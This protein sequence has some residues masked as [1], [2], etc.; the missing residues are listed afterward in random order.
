M[1]WYGARANACCL[2]VH[3]DSY[4]FL[5]LSHSISLSCD[6]VIM[7]VCPLSAGACPVGLSCFLSTAVVAA[8]GGG[9]GSQFALHGSSVTGVCI[10]RSAAVTASDDWVVHDAFSEA[11]GVAAQPPPQTCSVTR[12]GPGARPLLC[13]AGLSCVAQT[14]TSSSSSGGV[15][16]GSCVL[17]GAGEGTAAGTTVLSDYTDTAGVVCKPAVC[18]R[19][20]GGACGVTGGGACGADLLCT[21]VTAGNWEGLARCLDARAAP[22]TTARKLMVAA[23]IGV[24]SNHSDDSVCGGGNSTTAPDYSLALRGMLS[25]A[26]RV[27]AGGG[28][29][30]TA[31]DGTFIVDATVSPAVISAALTATLALP[32]LTA[33]L[34]VAQSSECSAD[35]AAVAG[36]VEMDLPGVVTTA[37]RLRGAGV[38]HCT[39]AAPFRHRLV[40][41]VEGGD[42][43]FAGGL[44]RLQGVA[45][46]VD[47]FEPTLKPPVTRN[48]KL[49]FGEPRSYFDFDFKLRHYTEDWR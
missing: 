5:S 48:S 35:G 27:T 10:T 42:V 43:T 20:V 17:L 30:S 16:Y 26:A 18:V 3:A 46:Q 33:S 1:T 8:A 29:A 21:P 28:G 39:S 2:L 4:V 14:A 47:H 45:M 13:A 12:C 15:G 32:G 9:T 37:A 40:A 6:V 24:Y 41:A 22:G 34:S 7:S 36:W 49:R 25:G 19:S 11:R 38:Q 44:L 23:A 31:I